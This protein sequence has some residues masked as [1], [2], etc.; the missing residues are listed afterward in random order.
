MADQYGNA[1]WQ[2]DSRHNFAV[3]VSLQPAGSFV[4]HPQYLTVHRI[5]NDSAQPV[6]VDLAWE[7]SV[8][9]PPIT[10]RG[11]NSVDVSAVEVAVRIPPGT[12]LQG[13]IKGTY[14]LLC[15]AIGQSTGQ[16][17]A[18]VERGGSGPSPQVLET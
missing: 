11:G 4:P 5:T 1:N 8:R 7:G 9:V 2:L 18:P 17:S 3:L 10:L 12:E 13:V 6:E 15:C 16:S 14:Q